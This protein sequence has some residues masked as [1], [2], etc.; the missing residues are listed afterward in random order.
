MEKISYNKPNEQDNKHGNVKRFKR[1][2]IIETSV[3]Q[4]SC[5][6][7]EIHPRKVKEFNRE[8][9][10]IFQS[11][12]EMKMKKR[13]NR[14]CVPAAGTVQLCDAVENARKADFKTDKQKVKNDKNQQ[15]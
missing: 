10:V 13:N 7:E 12:T 6:T 11:L 15:S 1:R 5:G 4:I 9:I 2:I 14:P 8:K 3:F